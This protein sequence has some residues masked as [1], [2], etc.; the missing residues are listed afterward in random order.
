MH[1]SNPAIIMCAMFLNISQERFLALQK[2]DQSSKGGHDYQWWVPLTFTSPGGDGSF[3]NTYS[4][5]WLRPREGEKLLKGMPSKDKPVIFNVKQNGN[6]NFQKNDNVLVLAR[7]L[8]FNA[9]YY[10]VN[11]DKRNWELLISALSSDHTSIHVTNRAQIIDDAFN[12]ARAGKLD[13]ELALQVT[14]YLGKEVEYLPWNSALSG[15]GYLNTMLKRTAAYGEFK[16]SLPF[17]VVLGRF[18]FN[19]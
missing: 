6:M 9:A 5:Y 7:C 17:A 15:L 14:S 3:N 12:L 4:K 16:V 1:P 13:Y 11:Y 10:R 19:L 8:T 18:S 2:P